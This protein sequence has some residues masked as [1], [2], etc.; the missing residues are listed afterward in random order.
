MITLPSLESLEHLYA[1]R[2][3]RHYG[4]GVTQIEHALQCQRLPKRKALY[5]A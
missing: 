2:G 3:G 4:E 1:E 5:Q